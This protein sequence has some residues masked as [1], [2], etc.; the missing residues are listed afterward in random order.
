MFASCILGS[1]HHFWCVENVA[2][3]LISFDQKKK[4]KRQRKNHRTQQINVATNH[5]DEVKK[6]Q[7]ENKSKF[8]RKSELKPQCNAQMCK[9]TLVHIVHTAQVIYRIL[10]TVSGN[11]F[12]LQWHILKPDKRCTDRQTDMNENAEKKRIHWIMKKQPSKVMLL[13]NIICL[14]LRVARCSYFFLAKCFRQTE[15]S[16]SHRYSYASHLASTDSMWIVK[17]RC[18][19]IERM[20]KEKK[21][22]ESISLYIRCVPHWKPL[23]E[24]VYGR[25]NHMTKHKNSQL[26]YRYCCGSL[27]GFN[28][29]SYV[30]IQRRDT[31]IRKL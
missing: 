8:R 18:D 22:K 26:L 29:F 14:V 7:N 2:I 3:F 4:K 17:M 27:V 24:C 15:L 5:L 9:R 19:R 28:G 12:M 25:A 21:K 30:T 13:L 6:T 10:E 1:G 16:S 11:H 23:M 20:A 31:C